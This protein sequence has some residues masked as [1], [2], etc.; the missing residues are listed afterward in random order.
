MS[1]KSA[2]L[3][4]F[5][6]IRLAIWRRPQRVPGLSVNNE[7]SHGEVQREFIG[8]KRIRGFCEIPSCSQGRQASLGRGD[9]SQEDQ[10]ESS[11][12]HYC[13]NCRCKHD[14]EIF[15]VFT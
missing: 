12:S 8:I 13:I 3:K 15:A 7:V 9:G 14:N 6:V 4:Q 1:E 11:R 5:S 10:E 2:C